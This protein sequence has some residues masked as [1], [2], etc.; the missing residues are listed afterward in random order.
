MNRKKEEKYSALLHAAIDLVREKGFQQ[1]AVG[2]IVKR[3]GVAQGTFYIYFSAKNDLVPAIA[4]Y[5]LQQSLAQIISRTEQAQLLTD[6]VKVMIDVSFEMA[7]EFQEVILFCYSGLAY[8]HSFPRWEQIYDPYYVWFSEQI[9]EAAQR[10]EAAEGTHEL[11]IVRMLI[12][13]MEQTAETAHFVDKQ[14]GIDQIEPLK[15]QLLLVI[16]RAL[17]IKQ[18]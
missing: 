11:T 1:T 10:G 7:D 15:A 9:K 2:D 3:A 17:G 13:M 4:D 5:I 6:K 8:H 16:G 18:P 12:N 14:Q